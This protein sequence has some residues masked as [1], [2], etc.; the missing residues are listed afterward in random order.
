MIKFFESKKVMYCVCAVAFAL[1]VFTIVSLFISLDPV[2]RMIRLVGSLICL[3]FLLTYMIIGI[4]K[5][6]KQGEQEQE[7]KL[8]QLLTKMNKRP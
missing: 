1:A 8:T 5:M 7:E 6:R 3:V 4:R 2:F